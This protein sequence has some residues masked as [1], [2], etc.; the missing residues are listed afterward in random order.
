[1]TCFRV[2]Q[3]DGNSQKLTTIVDSADAHLAEDHRN[4]ADHRSPLDPHAYM[5]VA[6]MLRDQI[7]GG[8]LAPGSPTPSIT[9]L[10]QETGHA[11]QT[12]AKAMRLLETEGLLR[13]IPGLG[14]Y[15]N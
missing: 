12:R 5:R 7:S 13:R 15:V 14:Y 2:C 6:R 8:S 3:N 9:R 10:C 4:A 11:R 1:M